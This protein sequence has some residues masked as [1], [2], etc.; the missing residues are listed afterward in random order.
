MKNK[1]GKRKTF[2]MIVSIL[3][4]SELASHY[5]ICVA[6]ENSFYNEGYEEG[7]AEG[8]RAGLREGSE[9]GIQTGY[10]RVIALGVLRGRLAIWKIKFM[11]EGAEHPQIDRIKKSLEGLDEMLKDVP[12]TNKD[13]DVAQLEGLVRKAKSKAKIIASL[14][15]DPTAVAYHDGTVGL[16]TTEDAIEDFRM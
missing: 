9:F 12:V 16:R 1:K 13:D 6:N 4:Q 14:I 10:Q 11:S 5:I 8:K 15:K 3:N 2:L 7:M